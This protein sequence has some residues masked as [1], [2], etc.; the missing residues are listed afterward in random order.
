MF[1]FESPWNG[2]RMIRQSPPLV[3]RLGER[4][5]LFCPVFCWWLK[6]RRLDNDSLSSSSSSFFLFPLGAKIPSREEVITRSSARVPDRGK[7]E[8]MVR[9]RVSWIR[10][11]QDRLLEEN[12]FASIVFLR[13]NLIEYRGLKLHVVPDSELLYETQAPLQRP[14]G[15]GERAGTPVRV[16]G[17]NARW[18]ISGSS[19]L[20]NDLS[21]TDSSS[22]S[23][24]WRCH[25]SF[26]GR[27]R[28]F[29]E[30]GREK[31]QC[32][33]KAGQITPFP[34]EDKEKTYLNQSI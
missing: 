32:R 24:S 17:D 7:E 1:Q 5:A 12:L 28:S 26:L 3:S 22:S 20:L 4:V 15:E 31:G 8:R 29:R 13:I 6:L 21:W 14:L 10:V 34:N 27:R 33:K 19:L 9:R 18:Q 11:F 2:Q 30:F 25:L 23:S 16:V